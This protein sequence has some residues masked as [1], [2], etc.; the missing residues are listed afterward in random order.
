MENFYDFEAYE[1]AIRESYIDSSVDYLIEQY[2]IATHIKGECDPTALPTVYKR[3]GIMQ[4]VILEE[5][6]KKGQLQ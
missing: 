4:K 3:I 1:T 2:E 6:D 5:L